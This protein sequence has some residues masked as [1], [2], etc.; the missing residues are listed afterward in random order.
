MR[1]S[2]WKQA[3]IFGSRQVSTASGLV[4]LGER[5]GIDV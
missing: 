2:T 1:T 3:A 5:G 4:L